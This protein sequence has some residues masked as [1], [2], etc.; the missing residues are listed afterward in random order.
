MSPFLVIKTRKYTSS[1]SSQVRP[2]GS[3]WLCFSLV[4][5]DSESSDKEAIKKESLAS[6]PRNTPNIYCVILK[7]FAFQVFSL[8]I[9]LSRSPSLLKAGRGRQERHRRFDAHF[10]TN[11]IAIILIVLKVVAIPFH[12][13]FM[14]SETPFLVIQ[15]I[16]GDCNS[17]GMQ[18]RIG[19]SSVH[20]NASLKQRCLARRSTGHPCSYL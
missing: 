9:R 12:W 10:I 11:Y 16:A 17:V 13:K 18:L 5:A 8:Y 4:T 3:G 14:V 15:V 7:R 19:S 6:L 1:P 2:S 20:Q